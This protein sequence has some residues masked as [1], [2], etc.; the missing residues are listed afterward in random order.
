MLNTKSDLR[1]EEV[2]VIKIYVVLSTN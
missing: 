2:V 1:R